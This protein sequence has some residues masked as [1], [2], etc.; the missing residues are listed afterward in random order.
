MSRVEGDASVVGVLG[1][2]KSWQQVFR[3][4]SFLR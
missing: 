3:L 2:P 1:L 4:G